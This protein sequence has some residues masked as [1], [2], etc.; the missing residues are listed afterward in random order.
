MEEFD[1]EDAKSISEAQELI[2]KNSVR[3]DLAFIKANLSFLAASIKKLETA[4][5]Q[6]FDSLAIVED[7]KTKVN[8]IPGQNGEIFKKKLSKVLKKNVGLNV[9]QDVGK[10]LAGEDVPLPEGMGPADVA[11]LKYCPISSVDAERSFS[12]FGHVFNE[13][14]HRFTEENLE[15]V[16]IANCY[17][18]RTESI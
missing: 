1:P 3:A 13:R 2:A 10:V 17:F 8:A 7:T 18:A 16:V 11:E 5:L 14:R 9:L 15:K 4:G 12:Q 6:I